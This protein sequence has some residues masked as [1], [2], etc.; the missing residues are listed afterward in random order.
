[1]IVDPAKIASQKSVVLFVEE[2]FSQF[3]VIDMTSTLFQK[4]YVGS[5]NAPKSEKICK[6]LGYECNYFLM[7]ILLPMTTIF[8]PK[9]TPNMTNLSAM[10][11]I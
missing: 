6:K 9:N 10:P 8:V 5:Y 11:K 2:G 3:E 1:M 4:G 7:Q